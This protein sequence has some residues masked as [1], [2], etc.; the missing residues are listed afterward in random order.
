M[1]RRL[2]SRV[3]AALDTETIN[4]KAK[5][6]VSL[7]VSFQIAYTG[8]AALSDADL[9]AMDV[10]VLRVQD[11]LPRA[12]SRIVLDG[13]REGYSPV[14]AVHN[15]AYDLRFLMDYIE[16]AFL[17]GYEIECCFK[18]SIKPLNV[19]ICEDGRARLIFWDTLTFSGMGLAR[20]GRQCGVEKLVGDW[21]YTKAR[22]AET[23]LD[24]D[25]LAYAKGD[26]ITLLNWLAYW[27]RLNP[28][29]KPYELGSR[30][31]TKTSVVRSKCRGIT[32]R[33]KKS[34]RDKKKI[35][36]Y[37][38]FLLTCK[39]ELPETEADYNLMI[40][41]TSAGWAFT[42]SEAAGVTFEHCIKIDARSMHPSH[43]LT[44]LYPRAFEIVKGSD[45]AAFVFSTICEKPVEK[46]IADWERPFAYAFNA[47]VKFTNLRLKK[48]SIFER[49]GIGLHGSGLFK[50]Y[51]TRFDD[52]DDEASNREFNRINA[53]GYSNYCVKGRYAFGKLVSADICVISLNEINAWVHAQVYEWDSFEVYEMSASATFKRVPD[54]VHACVSAMIERKNLVKSMMGGH[55]VERP[56]WM[57]QSAYDEIATDPRSQGAKDYYGLVKADV[58][59]LYGMFATNEFKQEISYY[60]GENTFD[61]A[62]ESGFSN[63]PEKP[64]AWYQFGLRIAAFSRLQQCIAMVLLDGYGVAR[65]FVNGDTDSL[66]VEVHDGMGLDDVI[67][68]LDELHAVI[69]RGMD[70]CV[71]SKFV[72][73]E[74]FE[75]LGEYELDC[76]PV[77]YCAVANKRYAYLD[78]SGEI[79]TASAGVPVKS[80]REVMEY[81]LK[82]GSDFSRATIR[83]LGYEVEYVGSISGTKARTIPKWGETLGE[84]LEIVDWRGVPFTYPAETCVGIA[85]TDT[86]KVLGS[87]YDFDYTKCCANAGLPRMARRHYE[88]VLTTDGTQMIGKW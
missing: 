28:E 76:L 4:A 62:G 77:K 29:T 36:L 83:A 75:G 37:G 43:M 23:P 25:E 13:K 82:A 64:K 34:W 50:D 2:P 41:S 20:M 67:E 22:H 35:S 24:D 21:D 85:L 69:R 61:Y 39:Q 14:V 31:L 55:M 59:S 63:M 54:H 88:K 84:D 52:Y 42:A 5:H 11:D 81:E 45:R 79:H 32:S 72:N 19:S 48:G 66:A 16:R 65:R 15:L 44:H 56:D 74:N 26:C 49:D 71:K 40:R 51:E 6:P 17:S 86:S 1:K 58:N 33:L 60:E 47:R 87:G 30:I 18:S 10:K 8:G 78:R 53:S 3:V 12:L 46:V 7:P 80:T 68:A 57:P 70:V 9:G 27:E 38:E 73:R